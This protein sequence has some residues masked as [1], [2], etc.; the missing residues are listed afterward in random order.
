QL[1]KCP[2]VQTRALAAAG[3]NPVA[4]PYQ[5]FQGDST[6]GALRRLDNGF[7][8]TVIGV[9]LEAPLLPGELLQLP[10]G[11]FGLPPLQVT[12]PVGIAP[13]R[14]VDFGAAID[15]AITI[16]GEVDNPQI[17]PE[18]VSNADML[19]VGDVTGACQIPRLTDQYQIDFAFAK[20]QQ[21]PLP[22]PTDEGQRQA[23]GECPERQMSIVPEPKNT[24][25]VELGSL[26]PH[27]E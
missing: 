27:T 21:R 13:T 20:R 15:C 23:A 26:N 1:P 12:A 25:T 10:F 5:I 16:N 4:Y 9:P 17:D 18:H 11:G 14:C 19:G 24:P 8:D 2:V 6:T 22:V 3:L 7:A